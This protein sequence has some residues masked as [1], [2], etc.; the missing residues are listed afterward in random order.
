MNGRCVPVAGA[1]LATTAT[2]PPAGPRLFFVYWRSQRRQ[3]FS[4]RARVSARTA[5]EARARRLWLAV[6]PARAAALA[7]LPWA[8]LVVPPRR[9]LAG[10]LR[11]ELT[12]GALPP[13]A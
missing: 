4:F 11:V 12:R 9:A 8:A 2:E 3:F 1:A 13:P 7:A 6:L 10:F 5:R